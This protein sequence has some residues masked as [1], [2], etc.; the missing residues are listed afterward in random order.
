MLRRLGFAAV[1]I[2]VLA[3][4][5]GVGLYTKG[6][7]AFIAPGPLA[8]ATTVLIPKGSGV[9]KIANILEQSD[10]ID[11]PRLFRIAVRLLGKDKDLR[12]GEYAFPPHVSQ[13]NALDILMKGEVVQYSITIPEGWTVKTALDV[14]AA[15][16][17]LVGATP[18]YYGEG[19]LL[20][21]TYAF[22]K[23]ET[24]EA[25]VKRMADAMDK[26]LAEAWAN[27]APDLP[28][29]SPEEALILASIVERETGISNEW[30]RVAGVFINRLR[31]GMRLQSDPTVIYGLSDGTGNIPRGITRSD[32][33]AEHPYN[34]YIIA[35]LP[36]TPIALP[37]KESIQAVL[38]PAKTKELYFVADGTGGHVFS[39]S[40]REHNNN[41]KKWR[42]IEREAK[43]QATQ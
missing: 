23:G 4:I 11:D 5:V 17:N 42:R 12:A 10:V 15:E 1:A 16:P 32:L 19:A 27:R 20:P 8:S 29:D 9:A 28:L 25:V 14:V 33:A 35:G 22:T 36:P 30:T 31:I 40:L 13:V 26:T 43:R 38:N 3:S 39:T 7:D 6:R 21:E 37:G 34:T 18:E 2:W 24:R 41:V